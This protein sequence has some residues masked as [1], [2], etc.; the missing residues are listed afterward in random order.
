MCDLLDE[1]GPGLE[2]RDAPH[3]PLDLVFAGGQA[4]LGEGPPKLGREQV[5][6]RPVFPGPREGDRVPQGLREPE[7]QRARGRADLVEPSPRGAQREAGA[8]DVEDGG[9]PDGQDVL[10]VSAGPVATG[11]TAVTAGSGR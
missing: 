1:A 8:G 11:V 9:S 3:D 4:S 10:E 5:P 6:E 2:L 7:L